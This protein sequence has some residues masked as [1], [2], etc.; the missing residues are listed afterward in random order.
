MF[1]IG[2]G[3]RGRVFIRGWIYW[4]VLWL[5]SGRVVVGFG[6]FGRA[7]C[8]GVWKG[9]LHSR[10]LVPGLDARRVGVWGAGEVAEVLALG[11]ALLLLGHHELIF[12][13]QQISTFRH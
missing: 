4:G 2:F 7:C 6:A 8:G 9:S 5:V 10:Q 13:R 1:I 12:F 11:L 3:A